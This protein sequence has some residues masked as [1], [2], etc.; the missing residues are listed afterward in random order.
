MID[1]NGCITNS[2][3]QSR[4]VNVSSSTAGLSSSAPDGLF[5]SGD[6]VNFEAIGGVSYKW[7]LNGLEQFDA[8]FSNLSRVYQIMIQYQSEY[9]M[10]MVVLM[11]NL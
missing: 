7:Y 6:V 3:T 2:A 11:R 8:T 9:L 5:C 10:L 4:T 1:G